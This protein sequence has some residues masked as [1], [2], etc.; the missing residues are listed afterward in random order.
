MLI[1]SKISGLC[2][3]SAAGAAGWL[4][5]L[6]LAWL[7]DCVTQLDVVPPQLSGK[8]L[9]HDPL[10]QGTMAATW[11]VLAAGGT[12]WQVGAAA[13]VAVPLV[14]T[15]VTDLRRGFVYSVVAVCGLAV[16]IALAPMIHAAGPGAGVA[17]ALVG[18]LSMAFL[19]MV[20][21]VAHP[22]AAMGRGDVLT[23][24]MVGAAAGPEVLAVLAVGLILNAL[25]GLFVLRA[26]RST[27]ASMPYAPGLCVGGVVSLVLR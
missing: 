27:L 9:V 7:S 1:E 12:S 11:M 15:A 4:M 10:L 16:S 19:R 14:Q 5:G 8:F 21:R 25:V 6:V 23:A 22:A 13:L 18:L 20:G 2:L 3:M 26:N 24:G 17:G